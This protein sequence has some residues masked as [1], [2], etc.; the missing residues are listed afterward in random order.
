MSNIIFEFLI[1]QQFIEQN[2]FLLNNVFYKT[3]QLVDSLRFRLL[4]LLFLYHRV[5]LLQ[6]VRNSGT[7][8]RLAL[9][10][11]RC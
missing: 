9:V 8:F 10:F 7:R 2:G 6:L 5:L 11:Q 4:L 3:F 1:P